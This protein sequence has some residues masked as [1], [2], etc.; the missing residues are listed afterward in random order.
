MEAVTSEMYIKYLASDTVVLDIINQVAYKVDKIFQPKMKILFEQNRKKLGYP[1]DSD[2][3]KN[4]NIGVF[5]G[6][7]KTKARQIIKCT[8]DYKDGLFIFFIY[9]FTVFTFF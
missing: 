5:A 1:L 4:K 3:I 8:T 7:I 9:F 6:P 2:D